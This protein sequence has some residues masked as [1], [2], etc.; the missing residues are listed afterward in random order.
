MPLLREP[1]GARRFADVAVQTLFDLPG[2]SKP[3]L[4]CPGSP[5]MCTDTEAERLLCV[6]ELKECGMDGSGVLVAVVDTGNV[7]YLISHGKSQLRRRARLEAGIWTRAGI[8]AVDHRTICAFD[9]RIAVPI[10]EGLLSDAVLAYRQLLDIMLAPRRPGESRSMVVNNSW[11]CFTRAG[12]FPAGDHGN[13]SDNP[14]YRLTASS[15]HWSAPVPTSYS[16]PVTAIP[17]ARTDAVRV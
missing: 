15:V 2:Q 6:P 4:I 11:A 14:N 17:T 7:S 13:Y 10:M 3:Y 9:V 5:P 1:G 12:D 16:P 8:N